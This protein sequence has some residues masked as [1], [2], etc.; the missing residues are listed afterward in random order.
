MNPKP[1]ALQILQA[2]FPKLQGGLNPQDAEGNT[3]LYYAYING[4]EKLCM[5]LVKNG[6]MLAT[7]N[8][9]GGTCFDV[10]VPTDHLLRKL[11][12]LIP[13]EQPWI[14]HPCCQVCRVKFSTRTRKHHWYAP[15]GCVLGAFVESGC[16]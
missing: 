8:S 9:Q 10:R 1:N 16:H 6:A 4:A 14:E 12:L 13:R 7:P 3:P 5:G 2:L 11:L 15:W